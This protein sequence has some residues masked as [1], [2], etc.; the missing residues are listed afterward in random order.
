MNKT[1]R[2]TL[3]LI[4]L[5]LAFI[6]PDGS[7]RPARA[8]DT[9]EARSTLAGLSGVAIFVEPLPPD[10]VTSGMTPEMLS[11]EVERRL[12]QAGV[13]VLSIDAQ[14]PSSGNPVLYVQATVLLRDVPEQATCAIRMEVLQD[15]TLER[16]GRVLTLR[17]PTWGVGGVGI[18]TRR[19]RQALIDDVVAFT[20]QFVVAYVAA[21]PVGTVEE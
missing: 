11:G 18:Y 9:P 21:N 14:D 20:D 16:G 4:A 3:F 15:L 8:Q 19:W 7:A 2:P 17:A 10:V 5:L 1:H 6:Q 13:P 12:R